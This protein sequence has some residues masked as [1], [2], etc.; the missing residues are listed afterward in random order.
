MVTDERSAPVHSDGRRHLL[1][2]EDD[3][4]IRVA[5]QSGLELHGYAVTAVSN[6]FEALATIARAAPD[7][8]V[9]D[10]AMPIMSGERFVE[11]LART[12]AQAR[13]RIVVLSADPEGAELARSMGADAF[14]RKPLALAVL[15]GE[16]ERALN[17]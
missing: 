13:P 9:L 2:V 15:V 1:V 5:L 6:G 11:E 3:P 7:L 10:L 12:G 8:V 16:I 14:V 17:R 4:I